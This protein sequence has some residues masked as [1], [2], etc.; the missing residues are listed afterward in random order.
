MNTSED[1]TISTET[2]RR[3]MN[4][5]EVDAATREDCRR[6]VEEADAAEL[7][8]VVAIIEVPIDEPEFDVVV[9]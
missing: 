1:L 7:F 8:V 4:S 6:Q 2:A 9:G 5:P 3:W